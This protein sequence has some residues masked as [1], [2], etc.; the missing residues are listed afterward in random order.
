MPVMLGFGWWVPLCGLAAMV[1]VGWLVIGRMRWFLGPT[2]R[3]PDNCGMGPR[4]SALQPKPPREDP[5]AIARERY[6]KG[7]ISQEEFDAIVERL[8]KTERND[9]L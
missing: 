1:F 8:V 2:A 4:P 6:A 5:L 7:L 3:T 9:P